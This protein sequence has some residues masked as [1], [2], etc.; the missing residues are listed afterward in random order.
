MAYP[1]VEAVRRLRIRA[2]DHVVGDG[3]L[4]GEIRPCE[5]MVLTA[6]PLHAGGCKG[7]KC[8]GQDVVRSDLFAPENAVQTGSA[9]GPFRED[10]ADARNALPLKR[11]VVARL[12]WVLH[13]L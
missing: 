6:A 1:G 7:L 10:V 9:N 3:L 4:D 12:T 5:R 13:G 8:L 11:L 2:G